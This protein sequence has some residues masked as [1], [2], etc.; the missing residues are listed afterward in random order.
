MAD[1][2]DTGTDGF[3][4]YVEGE[5]LQYWIDM[6]K[7]AANGCLKLID[8]KMTLQAKLDAV[9]EVL[10]HSEKVTPSGY[11]VVYRAD[12]EEALGTPPKII[13]PTKNW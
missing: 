3:P 4:E 1:S 9:Q 2:A 13:H 5:D 12:I 8:E 7:Y 10:D 11:A 6:W